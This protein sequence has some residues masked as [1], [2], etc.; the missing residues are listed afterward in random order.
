MKYNQVKETRPNMTLEQVF[1]AA[2][3]QGYEVER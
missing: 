3:E 2:V 1:H